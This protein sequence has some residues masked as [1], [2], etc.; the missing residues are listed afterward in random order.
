MNFMQNSIKNWLHVD[1]RTLAFFRIMFGFVGLCD[2]LR[3]M[4]VIDVFYSNQGMDFR[5]HVTSKYSIKYFS[6]L[7][8]FHSSIEVHL[9]FIITAICFFLLII[10]YRTRLFQFLSAMGLISIHNA[11]IIVENGADMVLN[12]YLVW[13]LFLPLGT[14]WSVDAIRKSLKKNPD[15]DPNDLNEIVSPIKTKIF[16][17]GYL[18]CLMQ[19]SMIYFYN[20]M[21]KTGNM[22]ADGTAIHYMY[23]LETFLTPMGEWIRSIMSINIIKLLTK[24]TLYVE[25]LAPI[26]ILSPFFQPWL[27]RGVF[28]VFMVFHLIIALSVNIGM[29]SWVMMAVLILLLGSREMELLKN[30]ISRYFKRKYVVFYDR[31]CGFCHLTARI[32]KRMDGCS[33][34]IW[35]DR[36]TEGERPE[37]LDFLL[38]TSIVVWDSSTGETWLR[39]KAF[40]KIISALPFGFLMAW[41]F[42]I[43]GLEKIFGFIY[44]MISRNRTSVSKVLGLSA[45]GLK[46]EEKELIEEKPDNKVLV[47]SRKM[48]WVLSNL[49]VFLLLIGVVDYSMRIND[50]VKDV[51]VNE[52]AKSKRSSQ[53]Q[54]FKK[55]RKNMK[56]IL[57]YPRM[58]QEWNMFSPKVIMYETWVLAD[59]TFEN[60]E[61]L[62]L[63]QTSDDI[64]N[65]FD[66][67]YFKPYGNQFWRKLF[68]R[69]GKSQYNQH[70]PKF[71]KWLKN[72]D[73][74]SEYDGRKVSKVKFWKLSERSLDPESLP[75]NAKGVTM[76]ELKKNNKHQKNKKTPIKKGKG[77]IPVIKQKP[78]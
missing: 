2:V 13:A 75:E 55:I 10:G 4:G 27:R 19:L 51:F 56:R 60:G 25:L 9:F 66:R 23:Q 31:D 36:L 47:K 7:D 34:L 64:K 24:M 50:G 62:T 74:F 8:H 48:I 76:R 15:H 33:R 65:K 73:Y 14:S 46:L 53:P 43:P 18:A 57:L 77:R 63:F 3:R 68:G 58:Y 67:E 69:I 6:L 78:K 39:H 29:F 1:T 71:K 54:K 70:I 42:K 32:L 22:W 20:H 16:H 21:N 72:T 37:K 38:E 41:I 44:D 59:L 5:R 11:A 52:E 61:E 30:I 17:L 49:V 28:F 45:C 26:A 35:A 12:N 40:S